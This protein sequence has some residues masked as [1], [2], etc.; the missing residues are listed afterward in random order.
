MRLPPS[1]CIAIAMHGSLAKT[2]EVSGARVA[3]PRWPREDP[4]GN[5]IA[6]QQ[7]AKP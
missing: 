6:R 2:R 1:P 7:G 3:G 5:L 4:Y